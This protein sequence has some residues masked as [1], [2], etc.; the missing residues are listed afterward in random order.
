MQKLS[1]LTG[2][3]LPWMTKDFAKFKTQRDMKP[4]EIP[5]CR[6]NKQMKVTLD[7]CVIFLEQDQSFLLF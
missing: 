2:E 3:N 7:C 5:K 1:L 6:L 4:T